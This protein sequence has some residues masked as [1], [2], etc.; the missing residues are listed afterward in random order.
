MHASWNALIKTS[1]NTSVD[2]SLVAVV[3]SFVALLWLP[4]VPLPAPASWPYLGASCLVELIYF[5]VLAAVY[6][7]GDLSYAYP[8]MRGL[9]PPLVAAGGAILLAEATTP[10]M[11]TG[12]AAI[13]AGVLWIGGGLRLFTQAP[14]R[15]TALALANAGIIASYT[16][17]DGVGVRLSG[18]P[19]SYGFWLFFLIGIP[20]VPLLLWR[21]AT[22]IRAHLRV[23]WWRSTC[24]GILNVAVYI[25]VLW[26]MTQAPVA[27]VAA[28]RE[29]SVIFGALIG[30]LL[31][32]EPFGRHRVAGACLIVAGVALLRA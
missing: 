11:W 22:S 28:L 5:R 18:N 12:I 32:K 20:M 21:Q 23:Q 6:R 29:T 17:I 10:W 15:V 16:L 2:T 3:S 4:F 8:L 13:S 24:G 14:A 25:I 30:A 27:A 19:A 1:R 26:A 9:A 7:Q 31:L